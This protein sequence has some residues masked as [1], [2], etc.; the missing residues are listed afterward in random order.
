A[1]ASAISAVLRSRSILA[2]VRD[3]SALS[4]Q[5]ARRERASTSA[6]ADSGPGVTRAS[7]ASLS[8]F[9]NARDPRAPSRSDRSR[10]RSL[11]RPPRRYGAASSSSSDAGGQST[12][13]DVPRLATVWIRQRAASTSLELRHPVFVHRQA[14]HQLLGEIEALVVGE[15]HRV[16]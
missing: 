16:L 5:R 1:S 9:Q 11:P 3:A 8:S 15:R 10:A 2:I 13:H 12:L 14:R 6:R 7:I 4:G